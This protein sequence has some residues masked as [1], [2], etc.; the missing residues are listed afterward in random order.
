M[1]LICFM[2][3]KHLL[4]YS[5][6]NGA[7]VPGQR[8]Y[9]LCIVQ[10]G[11][12][13]SFM[14]DPPARWPPLLNLSQLDNTIPLSFSFSCKHTYRNRREAERQRWGP[15]GGHDRGQ[16][17]SKAGSGPHSREPISGCCVQE[18]T[19]QQKR[20]NAHTVNSNSVS[21]HAWLTDAGHIHTSLQQC[22]QMHTQ[23]EFKQM[24]NALL[25]GNNSAFQAAK[26]LV[27]YKCN[28]ASDQLCR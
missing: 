25:E 2:T 5:C 10:P 4:F 15:A 19:D 21:T 20:Q 28:T 26:G 8:S 6:R 22:T 27:L 11:W 18:I 23:L 12:T 16:C 17:Y 9:G 24:R 3:K 7:H 14:S 1:D 13:R